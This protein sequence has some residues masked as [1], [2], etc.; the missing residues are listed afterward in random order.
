MSLSLG[1]ARAPPVLFFFRPSPGPPRGS[2]RRAGDAL[3]LVS[4]HP[5]RRPARPRRSAT[6]LPASSE[7]TGIRRWW[8]PRSPYLVPA[9]VLIAARVLAW[10]SLEFA[11]EDAYITF[12]FARNLAAGHGLVYNPGQHVWGFSSPP[13][14]VWIALGFKLGLSPVVWT[15]ASAIVADLVTVV[16]GARLLERHA[17]RASAWAFALFFAAWPTFSAIS[18][19]GMETSTMLAIALGAVTLAGAGSRATGPA[20]AAL[21][22]MRPEGPFAA[23]PIL[24]LARARDRVVAGALFAA[25]YGW[26]AWRFGSLVPQSVLAKASIYGTPGPWLGRHWWEWLVPMPLGRAPITG[27][28]TMLYPLAIVMVSAFAVGLV[29]LARRPRTALAVAAAS[30][31]VVWLGYAT[32]GV[33][34][35]YWY[36]ALPLAGVALVASVGLPRILQLKVFAVPLLLFLA[37]SWWSANFLYVGRAKNEFHGFAQTADY[38]YAHARPGQAVLLEPIG[39]VGYECPLVVVDEVGLVS[40]EVARRRRQGAGWYTDVVRERR[41]D[42]IVVRAGMLHRQDAFAGVGR[43]FRS[44]AE[45]DSLFAGYRQETRVAETAGDFALVIFHRREAP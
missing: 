31:L 1:Q 21:A 24:L 18:I 40:P 45:R 14:T 20:I 25:G 23:L 34:Y 16:L 43:P 4:P 33:A 8:D 22:L 27:E 12:R 26:L 15:R 41:P 39:M 17:S 6:R 3:A 19:S 30:L 11:G 42:W 35:F 13:W 29:T 32:L 38:L 7:P 37:G 2:V 10:W 5:S 36:M 9:I 28:G 44:A